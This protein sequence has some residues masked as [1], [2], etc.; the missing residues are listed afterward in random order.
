MIF[1]RIKRFVIVSIFVSGILIQL[2]SQQ[3]IAQGLTFEQLQSQVDALRMVGDA[4]D[5]V[6]ALV[7]A[8]L[9]RKD[10]DQ[11]GLDTVE[12]CL[13]AV[14]P[15]KTQRTGISAIWTGFVTAP[16]PGTYVF[17]ISPI[18]VN[19]SFG[20]DRVKHS[21]TV[22]LAG[23]K[24]LDSGPKRIPSDPDI[25]VKERGRHAFT[26]DER[27]DWKGAP[28]DLKG[29]E[30]VPIRIE[31]QF[32]CEKQKGNDSP[33]AM[34]FWEGPGTVRQPV[35]STALTLPDS[36]TNGLKAEYQVTEGK[37]ASTIEQVSSNVEYAWTT[38]A[39]AAPRN[40]DL[41]AEL[42]RRLWTLSTDP[43]FVSQCAAGLATHPYFQDE[44]NTECLSC[45][46]REQFAK[47]LQN[48]PELMGLQKTCRC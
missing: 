26:R 24:V 46:Q 40:P 18:N 14:L 13:H 31:M 17:S 22:S 28:I 21:I 4:E 42:T 10:I 11:L 16:R 25:P 33:S 29:G 36:S 41:V 45:A 47:L 30:P 32:A 7:E 23:T 43:A 1:V 39:N 34:L 2:N 19:K 38:P 27:W 48:N 37:D 12:W 15:N 9:S 44:R 8:W 3:V 35:P 6:P 5:Q 20:L